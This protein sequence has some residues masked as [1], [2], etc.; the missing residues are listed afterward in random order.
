[1]LVDDDDLVTQPRRMTSI[2]SDDSRSARQAAEQ[3]F[4]GQI[5]VN[6]QPHAMLACVERAEELPP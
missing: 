3:L 2:D 6:A 1:M 4:A 5:L